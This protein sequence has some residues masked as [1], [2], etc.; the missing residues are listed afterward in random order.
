MS[1]VE[2]YSNTAT[3]TDDGVNG[4]DPDPTDN[5]DVDTNIL[6]AAPAYDITNFDFQSAVT[7]GDT[8]TYVL[9]VR[10][11]GSQDGQNVV[12]T[13]TFPSNLIS[14]TNATGGGIIDNANGTV[15]WTLPLLTAGNAI[16]LT[17]TADVVPGFTSGAVTIVN[18]A[19]VTDD[20]VNGPDPDLSDNTANDINTIVA[21]PDYQLTLSDG[22]SNATP[23]DNLT[24]TILV[25]NVGDRDGENVTVLG[26]IP[27]RHIDKR[28]RISGR[29]RQCGC[30][31]DHVGHYAIGCR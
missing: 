6:D 2:D 3:V 5:Q 19:S 9:L 18:S 13:D 30:R 15:T 12:V 25:Q 29:H 22:I 17:V 4:S 27:N 21:A 26:S 1:G 7:S 20:G 24:Y 11:T 28:H 8:I 16:Q 31:Y 23:G 10:N 14:V